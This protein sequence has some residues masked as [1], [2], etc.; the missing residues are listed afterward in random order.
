MPVHADERRRPVRALL[1]HP[2]RPDPLRDTLDLGPAPQPQGPRSD[3]GLARAGAFLVAA[4][5]TAV[6]GGSDL[7]FLDLALSTGETIPERV[8][9]IHLVV[10]AS[11]IAATP[12]VPVTA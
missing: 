3:P 8:A 2:T 4:F 6:A 9:R 1:A 12:D 7:E 5:A 11:V 10:T